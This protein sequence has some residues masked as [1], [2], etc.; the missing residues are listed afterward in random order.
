M[1][2]VIMAVSVALMTVAILWFSPLRSGFLRCLSGMNRFKFTCKVQPLIDESKSANEDTVFCIQMSGRVPIPHDRTDTDV[3]VELMDITDSRFQPEPVL[4]VDQRYRS[5]ERADFHFVA[6]NG[7]IPNKNAIICP[8]KTVVEIPAHQLRFARRG[9]RKLLFKVSI[10]SCEDNEVLAS[11]QQT[12]EYVFCQDGYQELRDRKL[13]VLKASIGLAAKLS[14][15][16]ASLNHETKQTFLQWL[17]RKAQTFPAAAQLTEWVQ[18]LQI[19][20]C[21]DEQQTVDCLLAHAEQTEKF[22][23]I[24]LTL[25][26]FASNPAM[27]IQ[28]FSGLSEVV[29][30]LQIKNSRFLA[31]CQKLLLFSACKLEAPAL[32]LGIDESMDED[33]FR[34][35]LNEEYRKWNAR[36]THPDEKIRR[37]AD[38]MLSLIAQLRSRRIVSSVS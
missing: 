15:D 8:W 35:R 34:T 3:R 28:Q 38:R 24:E 19:H 17:N 30:K 36:V 20:D 31:L 32:L 11:S 18:S 14:A 37:Q 29:E 13:D 5:C 16:E 7:I 1:T 10:L 12:I 21:D 23:A 33:T 26:V 2:T 4:S 25:Q 27:T 9:R 6:H 22:A